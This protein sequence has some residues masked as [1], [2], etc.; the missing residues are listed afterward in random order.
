[1]YIIDL[2]GNLCWPTQTLILIKEPWLFSWQDQH[3]AEINEK[4]KGYPRLVTT[5]PLVTS[6]GQVL[7]RTCGHLTAGQL[8]WRMRSCCPSMTMHLCWRSSTCLNGQQHWTRHLPQKL[9][10][11]TAHLTGL[12]QPL[13]TCKQRYPQT[14]RSQVTLI[15][16]CLKIRRKRRNQGS[17]QKRIQMK[18]YLRSTPF[19]QVI[20][21]PTGSQVKGSLEVS[22][23]SRVIPWWQITHFPMG[24]GPP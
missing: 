1:M 15:Q 14:D 20:N 8:S 23:S 5:L 4:L 17:P 21:P 3:Q 22:A 13:W 9:L 10:P 2:T 12:H 7:H 24:L 11:L 18:P 19:Q 16:I 6:L